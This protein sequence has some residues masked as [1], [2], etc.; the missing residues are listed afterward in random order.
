[1]AR[2]LRQIVGER[3]VMLRRR[4][5]LTQP[6]LALRAKMGITTLN[7]VENAR[8]SMTM[9]K[10]VALAQVLG[11]STD[12][13]LGLSEDTGKAHEDSEQLTAAVA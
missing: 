9:E 13:L 3:V 4:L 7:R 6:E 1:M 8:S 12:Y 11:T 5:G 2:T 10:V